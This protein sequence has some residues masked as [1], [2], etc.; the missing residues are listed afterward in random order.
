MDLPLLPSVDDMV[1]SEEGGPIARSGFDYQDEIGVS[2]LLDMV[3]DTAIQKVHFE[4]HDD[5]VIVL[6]AKPYSVA[7][8][9]QVKAGEIN[10]L[11]TVAFVCKNENGIGTS[12]LERSLGRDSCREQSL[13]RLITLR[14][15]ASELKPLTFPR[16]AP[17]RQFTD[18][19][20]AA[21]LE[22]FED[23]KLACVSKKGN[24]VKFWVANCLWQERPDESA[25]REMNFSRL[26]RLA[27]RRGFSLFSEQSDQLLEDLRLWVKRA[28]AARWRSNRDEKIVTRV[29]ICSWLDRRLAEL[30][31]GIASPSGGKL[32]GKME[33][34]GL[35]EEQVR[36]A[37]DL[38]LS[39]AKVVRTSRYMTTKNADKLQFRVKSELASLRARMMAGQLQLDGQ[40]FHLLCL[41]RMDAIS[42]ERRGDSDD[43]SGF[44]KGC[45]YD[46]TDRCL[47][48][49]SKPA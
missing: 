28:G 22:A 37:V 19:A 48:R 36:M 4:T 18:P 40:G 3:E 45:M 24:D 16:D 11:W 33:E 12:I 9:V 13:F 46:I 32:A 17:G 20:M 7:E 5:L 6:A 1:P 10:Q 47:H 29:Q 25:I 26:V 41:E 21:L 44:L 42:S 39:Y 8:F 38:R 2:F 34:A 49:F 15:V 30:R 27:N 31:S 43:Q 35:S 23:K 14:Q